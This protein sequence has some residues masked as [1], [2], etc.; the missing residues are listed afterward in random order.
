MKLSKYQQAIIEELPSGR[1][2]VIE[3]AA[4]SGKTTTLLEIYKRLSGNSIFLA[5]STDV[6]KSIS[7]EIEA[8]T[9]NSIGDEIIKRNYCGAYLNKFKYELI[10]SEVLEGA[11]IKSRE[12]LK[13]FLKLFNLV[14]CELASNK[15]R[16][17]GNCID[18]FGSDVLKYMSLT[19][20]E[21]LILAVK[22][23][24]VE[25]FKSKKEYSFEDQVWLHHFIKMNH[26]VWD[27]VLVDEAQDLNKAQLKLVLKLGKRFI[28]CGDSNQCQP[29]ETLV[30]TTEGDL[31]IKDIRYGTEVQSYNI[32]T[33]WVRPCK[34]VNTREAHISKVSSS[35][36]LIVITTANA[37]SK[38]TYEHKW[39]FKFKST[40]YVLGKDES[41]LRI[42]KLVDNKFCSEMY[43]EH[44]FNFD[45]V[46]VHKNF[47]DARLSMS[48]LTNQGKEF[49]LSDH[50][51]SKYVLK[52]NLNDE[53]LI[54]GFTGICQAKDLDTE[55]MLLRTDD[56]KWVSFN[57]DVEPFNGKVY[58]L[59]V[60][61]QHTY[62]ADNLVT[63]NS[64]MGFSGADCYSMERIKKATNAVVLPLSICYRCPDSHLDLARNIVNS[65]ENGSNREG[66]VINITKAEMLNL[67]EEGDVVIS[68][69]NSSLIT[70][71][72]EL[73]A[74]GKRV[75][76]NK[77]DTNYVCSVIRS[78]HGSNIKLALDRWKDS[79]LK[80]SN[81]IQEVE[82]TYQCI[83]ACLKLNPNSSREELVDIIKHMKSKKGIIMSSIHK[84]K[85][86][87]FE[88]VYA[89]NIDKMPSKWKGQKSWQLRQEIYLKYVA[90]TRA[91]QDLY[92]VS[93]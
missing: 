68:R 79:Q 45:I 19:N 51:K 93:L 22:K 91:R 36:N 35:N 21:D 49:I 64:I 71:A 89:L 72:L 67:V 92:L 55:L 78:L 46:S 20:C 86:L 63:H 90:L 11:G 76:M 2:I 53:Y 62:I 60:M 83:L 8:R 6:V 75:N 13:S 26:K 27:N 30:K 87:E 44:L 10:C 12:A 39:P 61:Q 1:N 56:G 43:S 29:G 69:Y 24:G 37:V 41:S 80:K 18:H 32:F 15:D 85:G 70:C 38:C 14:Q 82:D 84:S 52:D 54:E 3:A 9:I 57:I 4:G 34:V 33:G 81:F 88:N 59:E 7:K 25:A 48:C 31:P 73:V 28:F 42:F 5:F 17:I 65:I 40:V 23:K 58:S 47:S 16:E 77:T 74:K 66:R 50:Y